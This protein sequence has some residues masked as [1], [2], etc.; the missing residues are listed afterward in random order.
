MDPL[1]ILLIVLVAGTLGFQFV[2]WRKSQPLD[3]ARDK[4]S[5]TQA[6]IL[7][8]NQMKNLEHSVK[9]DLLEVVKGVAET[10]ESTK[11]VLTVAEQL[12]NLEKV[13][14]NQKQRGNLGEASLELILSNV[15]PGQYQTQYLFRDGEKVDFI[16]KTQ[17]GL[18]PVDAKF[19]LENYMRLINEGDAERQEQYRKEFKNDVKKRIDET[20]K[21]IRPEEGT[22][23]FAFMYIPAEGIYYDL[24]NNDVGVGVNARDLIDYAYRQKS[25]IIVSPTTFLAYLQT[26][27]FGNQRMKVQE[28]AKD[29]IK[30]VSE[31]AKHLKV[32]ED[33]HN[34][35]GKSLNAALNHYD[36]SSKAFK[37]IDKDVV[38]IT[39]ESMDLQLEAA[40]KPL[41]E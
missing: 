29:I 16:V 1:V 8:Q 2:M 19:P 12:N 24:L 10:K 23:P 7:L 20:A 34:S 36:K 21:Y 11:Q 35:L 27:L 33:S 32:Y 25:V 37:A 22:L 26:V 17:E 9:H 3:D 41:L 38:R 15:L 31:L 6:F 28:A 13:L 4:Q 18:I 30:N 5:E 14:K 39:E 40:E